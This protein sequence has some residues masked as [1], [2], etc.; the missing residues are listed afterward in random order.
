MKAQNH[1]YLQMKF[2]QTRG[3]LSEFPGILIL[4]SLEILPTKQAA[5]SG[6]LM[7]ISPTKGGEI[8]APDV[9]AGTSDQH[10]LTAHNVH[11]I[12]FVWSGK[13]FINVI[14]PFSKSKQKIRKPHKF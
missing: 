5:S 13:C 14:N 11:R 6:P 10:T 8:I 3:R 4:G 12:L 9:P 1:E 7:A 2:S